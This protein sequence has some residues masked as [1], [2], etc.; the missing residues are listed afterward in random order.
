MGKQEI[1]IYMYVSRPK[2]HVSSKISSAPNIQGIQ[3]QDTSNI[4]NNM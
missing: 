3:L 1:N 4:A 2:K